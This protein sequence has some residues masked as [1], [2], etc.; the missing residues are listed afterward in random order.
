M[1]IKIYL[2]S[3]FLEQDVVTLKYQVNLNLVKKHRFLFILIFSLFLMAKIIYS[4]KEILIFLKIYLKLID[5]FL[6]K[7]KQL[8]FSSIHAS[9]SFVAHRSFLLRRAIFLFLLLY[10]FLQH[11]FR[12]LLFNLL[13]ESIHSFILFIRRYNILFGLLRFLLP[14]L[15]IIHFF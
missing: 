7:L 9:N 14:L 12:S 13:D 10:L 6:V 1:D 3:Y 11:L 4:L 2:C 5:C 15:S 8:I